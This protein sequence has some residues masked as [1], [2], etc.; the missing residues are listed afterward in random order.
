[1]SAET[2]TAETLAGATLAAAPVPIATPPPTAPTPQTP[3]SS[4][5][6]S[7]KR[8]FD[9]A[10]FRPE[11]DAVG[12]W[13][14]LRGGRKPGP[15]APRPPRP[16]TPPTPPPAPA[17]PALN[18]A[19]SYVSPDPK[20]APV[21]P[22]PDKY[23]LAAEMYCRAF[24]AAADGLFAGKGE[25]APDDDAEHV[26]L[27]QSAA[28]YM[29]AK[30]MEDLPPG[31]ALLIAVGTF[32][33]KRIQRPNTQTRWRLIVGYWKARFGAWR[34]GRKID[35][36]PSVQAQATTAEQTPQP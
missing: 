20:P 26:G 5:L 12:R 35:A 21:A 18:A 27:R 9:P 33:A 23:D 16:D 34:T 13:K 10:K 30:G 17:N 15:T 7:L 24:Y 32:G 36:L 8:P 11:K 19:P 31:P 3:L 14:N 22:G 2:I 6:D 4:E 28:A 25:W 1:M 29:R